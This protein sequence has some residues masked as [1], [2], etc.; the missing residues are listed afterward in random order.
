MATQKG[1]NFMVS[2]SSSPPRLSDLGFKPSEVW[3]CEAEALFNSNKSEPALRALLVTLKKTYEERQES[4]QLKRKFAKEFREQV[5]Q[6]PEKKVKLEEKARKQEE[7]ANKIEAT[8]K[9]VMSQIAQ[10][11]LSLGAQVNARPV[12]LEFQQAAPALQR[13]VTTGT[14]PITTSS[15]SSSSNCCSL[16][17]KDELEGIALQGVTYLTYNYYEFKQW[18]QKYGNLSPVF[19]MMVNVF[20]F[21]RLHE[22]SAKYH[23]STTSESYIGFYQRAIV[24]FQQIFFG[25]CYSYNK[26]ALPLN[27]VT[28][29]V[30]E[31]F[32][33]YPEQVLSFYTNGEEVMAQCAKLKKPST[34]LFGKIPQVSNEDATSNLRKLIQSPSKKGLDEWLEKYSHLPIQLNPQNNL[35]LCI[36]N[37]YDGSVSEE[38]G[39]VL[40]DLF[41]RF[42]NLFWMVDLNTTISFPVDLVLYT[43]SLSEKHRLTFLS[44]FSNVDTLKKCYYELYESFNKSIEKLNSLNLSDLETDSLD[45]LM[46][47]IR[48]FR[49]T[50][51]IYRL[52]SHNQY[53]PGDRI[54]LENAL[55]K[56]ILNQIY[57]AVGVKFNSSF[58]TKKILNLLGNDLWQFINKVQNKEELAQV[59]ARQSPWRPT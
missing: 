40:K 59:I 3:N 23:N 5:D 32:K 13:V 18:Y 50:S 27:F 57:P 42:I 10:E 7:E 19:S 53:S 49:F 24:F 9:E 38:E 30:A 15:Q 45:K 2:N 17:F 41:R 8:D 29:H 33:K 35:L 1:I 46:Q 31:V 21:L 4:I 12:P 20:A 14:A 6:K 39:K 11:I 22:I 37:K 56:L 58:L 44:K 25:K 16:K 54:K 55:E 36:I 28:C 52:F 34:S 51:S 47:D 26:I 43:S 48:Y